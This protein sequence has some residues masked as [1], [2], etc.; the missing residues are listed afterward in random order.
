MDQTGAT[1][2]AKDMIWKGHP[3]LKGIQ[4]FSPNFIL[5]IYVQNG[6]FNF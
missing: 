5:K 6:A 3:L 2:D 1:T 4:E